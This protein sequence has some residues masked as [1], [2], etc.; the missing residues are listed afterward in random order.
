MGKMRGQGAV[1]LSSSKQNWTRI[2]SA[3]K[4]DMRISANTQTNCNGENKRER[5]SAHLH[6]LRLNCSGLE[7]LKELPFFP[8]KL[9]HRFTK[10]RM[11]SVM[12]LLVI[13][14]I[15]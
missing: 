11:G 7:Q 4:Q 5:D 13:S 14:R 2:K 10:I 12:N 3:G 6:Q 1:R 9:T 15:S 8:R